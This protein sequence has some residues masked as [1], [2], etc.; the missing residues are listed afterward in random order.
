MRFVLTIFAFIALTQAIEFNNQRKSALE[1]TFQP[2]RHPIVLQESSGDDVS[3]NSTGEEEIVWIGNSTNSLGFEFKNYTPIED[4]RTNWNSFLL[5]MRSD[6]YSPNI[7]TCLDMS[8]GVYQYDIELLM[9][10]YMYGDAKQ[11]VL[12]TTLFLGNVSDMSYICI[13]A[14]ENLYVYTMYKF[15]LFG[16]DKNNVV[17]GALQNLLGSIL[18]INSLYG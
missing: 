8:I 5:G 7:S 4:F 10:K 16:R 1:K 15:D 18:T 17:L 3:S 11:N 12:N 13:D 2:A 14:A 6:F 9:I